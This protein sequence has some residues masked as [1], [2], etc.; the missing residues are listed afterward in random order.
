MSERGPG[1]GWYPDPAGSGGQRYFD[2]TS[3]T[4]HQ[5]PGW[6]QPPY[7]P[8]AYAQPWKGAALGR[9][10]NGPGSL[11]NPG[12]RLLARLLDGIVL[13]PLFVIIVGVTLAIVAP[14]VGP[15]FPRA[16]AANT[17]NQP[18]PGIF[19]LYLAFIGA[20]ALFWVMTFLYEAVAIGQFGRT[21]G[22]G[23]MHIRPVR[24]DGSPVG[25]SRAFG[26]VGVAL[27]AGIVGL[28]GLLDPLWCVWDENAQC[29]HD[30]AVGTIVINDA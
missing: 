4:P 23:W 15:V 14:H 27:A 5:I 13:L 11:A 26:R 1:P 6:T 20:T 18:P 21:L 25:W 16:N 28:P 3:W 29:L 22:K 12:T 10:A 2:G 17:G 9:P 19:W 24:M 7:F 30:K 8:A